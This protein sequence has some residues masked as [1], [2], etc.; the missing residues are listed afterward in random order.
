MTVRGAS[1][2][3]TATMQ[4]IAM[5]DGQP[6]ADP[7]ISPGRIAPR[8]RRQ[9]S[10]LSVLGQGA[11][12]DRYMVLEMVGTG[13]M[14]M[15]YAAYDP[16]LDRRVALK[17]LR[18]H[19]SGT[20]RQRLAR[21]ARALARLSHANV[22]QVYDVGVHGDYLFVAMELIEGKSLNEWCRSVPAPSWREILRVYL[23][24]ARG[25]TAAHEKGL[26]HRDIKPANI[27]IG[28]DGQV[29]VADFGLAAAI[30][31]DAGSSHDPGSEDSVY[32]LSSSESGRA[33]LSA[34]ELRLTRT[35]TLVG[36]PGFMAPEQHMGGEVGP[37]AD[38]Y[39][40]CA[41]LYQSLYGM[42]PF[43]AG[44]GPHKLKEL[45]ECK[46]AGIV[47]PP[48]ADTD[49]PAWLRQALLVGLAAAPED[50]Y[51][52][53][54]ALISALM[55]DPVRRRRAM[56]KSAGA[57]VLSA[58]LVT[59]A[60]L[61]W[62]QRSHGSPCAGV[63][64]ELAG[65]WNDD[66]RA[67]LEGAFAA[68]GRADASDTA[69]RVG[70]VLDRQAAAWIEL[71][72]RQCSAHAEMSGSELAARQE[73]CLMRRRSELRAVTALFANPGDRDMKSLL[74]NAISIADSLPAVALCENAEELSRAVPLPA[75]PAMRGHI[76]D[77]HRELDELRVL[78][79]VGRARDV[80]AR[81][82][83]LLAR[84]MATGYTPLMA[85]VMFEVA[86][87]EDDAGEYDSAE[88]TAFEAL[89]LAARARDDR[90]IAEIWSKWL[91]IVG[92]RRARYAEA[93]NMI[94]VVEVAAERAGDEFLRA[95]AIDYFGII[96]GRMGQYERAREHYQE[97]LRLFEK[98]LGAEHGVTGVVHGHLGSALANLG[99]FAES[100]VQH[101]R[102][103]EIVE[104]AYGANHPWIPVFVA[105][106]ASVLE[107]LGR[108]E[109]ANT[110]NQR[111]LSLSLMT[112]DADHPFIAR[113]RT[114][115]AQVLLALGELDVARDTLER[116]AAIHEA[117]VGPEHPDL[118]D[119]LAWLGRV[120]V[121]RGDLQRAGQVLE[122][123]HTIMA[124]SRADDHPERAV[125]LLAMGELALAQAR[126]REAIPP[127]SHIL[128]LGASREV[129]AA[130]L[131][132]ADAELALG[133]PRRAGEHALE[134]LAYYERIGHE[135]GTRA[136]RD[137]LARNVH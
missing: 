16:K 20:A 89:R 76:Q 103:L 127:L 6:G 59:V 14:S 117:A 1:S 38:R 2:G 104:R 34:R 88:H 51:P 114:Q 107:D 116:A 109:E 79:Q 5:A 55:A 71:R 86:Q 18:P 17:I 35:G 47:S 50:R 122:R 84:A 54:D 85:R 101:R 132:L 111:A 24:A 45:L 9:R 63:S 44:N 90:L 113:R 82:K 60:V 120:L 66:V 56:L 48:P 33:D 94:K 22:V 40:F 13:A 91:Y 62:T 131:A 98:V 57:V 49:V 27:L 58:A 130:R 72:A 134:A 135:P 97:A 77:L 4:A 137:W 65:V 52:S 108:F 25:I 121:A 96:Y 70:R 41:A 92:Y 32:S 124:L 53:M 61:G 37:A 28:T 78:R 93:M 30:D 64:R 36:T 29:R 31:R 128:S 129:G 115:L 19:G 15:V 83:A 21:E 74:A 26:V 133:H 43:T 46:L 105:N 87:I 80:L 73:Y 11:S 12:V 81:G 102:A 112:M 75:D 10:S 8:R 69:V 99:R 119:T 118:A 100:A 136:A 23:E 42:L 110:L 68:S 3:A 67:L 123:S 7:A 126:P 95:K 106:L 39:S 125:L